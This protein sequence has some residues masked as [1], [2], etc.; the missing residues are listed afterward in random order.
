MRLLKS[1]DQN[2]ELIH[3]QSKYGHGASMLH[4]VGANGVELWRQ[5]LPE[6]LPYLTSILLERGADKNALMKVYGKEMTPL[7]LVQSSEHPF[8]AG[9][10]QELIELL[11]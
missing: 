6:N 7:E 9:I 10:D 2:P 5:Q 11:S 1:L 3:Y 4:Y 8:I